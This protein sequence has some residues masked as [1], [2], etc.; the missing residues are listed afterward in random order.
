[1]DLTRLGL[2]GIVGLTFK[3]RI[4]MKITAMFPGLEKTMEVFV[5][6][7]ATD[8]AVESFYEMGAI[9]VEVREG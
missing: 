2:G 5:D 6:S 9:L 3:K 8:A 4:E 1:M 7:W